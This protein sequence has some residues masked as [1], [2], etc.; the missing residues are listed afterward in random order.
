[1]SDWKFRKRKNGCVRCERE[2][3]E[4]EVFYSCLLI[5]G[6]TIGREDRCVKCFV[7]EEVERDERHSI[8]WRT[9][10][11]V[12]GKRRL[13][14][15][16][17]VVEQLFL[18]L[19]EHTEE[20]ILELRYLMSLLLL[21]KKRLKLVRVTRNESE[22]AMVLRRPRRTEA[23]EVRVFDLSEDRSLQLREE[24]TRIFEGAEVED[25]LAAPAEIPEAPS[26]SEGAP[27]G[28]P[29]TA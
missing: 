17:D 11:P 6:V 2:F 21:R 12:D 14:V 19:A 24:L 20:R 27:R 16:F 29:E 28:A 7:P 3:E 22:E 8:Y 5:E 10:C 1:M 25:L 15:D 23:I 26:A 4:E 18:A 9:R 13:A